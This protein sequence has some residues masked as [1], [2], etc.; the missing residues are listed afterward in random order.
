MNKQITQEQEWQ[1]WNIPD[2]PTR[3]MSED[4]VAEW[5][6][7]CADVLAYA[8]KHKLSRAKIGEKNRD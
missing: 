4:D 1:G 8:E 6:R 2:A 3:P 7:V 5:R